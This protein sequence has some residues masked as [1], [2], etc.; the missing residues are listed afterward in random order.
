MRDICNIYAPNEDQP[1]FYVDVIEVT[2]NMSDNQIIV[3]DYN[4]VMDVSI[5]RQ[6]S[7]RNN[8]KSR[9][10]LGQIMDELLFTEVWRD[11]N[12][13]VRMFSWMR[14]KPKLSASRLDFALVSQ[15][16]SNYV[17][18][19]MYLPGI[20][21]DHLGFYLAVDLIAMD[22]GP[23]F[24][25]FNNTMLKDTE[26]IEN[27][28]TEIEKCCQVSEKM[29][30]VER[31]QYMKKQMIKLSQ[32][33]S[34]DKASE[35]SLIISQLSEKILYLHERIS[36][37][38][39]SE[40]EQEKQ[41]EILSKSKMDIEEMLEKKTQS[42][43]FKCETR[44]HEL[45]EVNSK[46]FFNLEKRRYNARVCA[47][48]IDNGVEYTDPTEILRKQERFYSDLYTSDDAVQFNMVN[49][50]GIKVPE[51]LKESQ[52]QTMSREEVAVALRQ[53]KNGKT[54]GISGLTTE[55]YKMFYCKFREIMYQAF[56]GLFE[57]EILP[58]D[59]RKGVINLIP[60]AGKDMRIL[61]NLRPI[62]LLDTD[63]KLIEKVLANRIEPAL[64][65]II[66]NDQQ[67]F[68]K[69]RRLCGNVRKILDLMKF[70]EKHNLE[71]MILS[72]DFM[73]CFDRIEFCAILGALKYFGFGEYLIN[74]VKVLY[75]D[76]TAVIQNN[77]FFSKPIAV[78]RG[79]HQ[80]GPMSSLLFLV[81]AEILAIELR[82]DEQIEGFSI[83]DIK[84]LLGQYADDMDIYLLYKQ[85]SLA[86][87]MQHLERFKMQSGFCVS[88]EKT[89]IYRIGSLKGSKAELYTHP[90]IRWTSD[91]ISVLGIKITSDDEEAIRLNYD[92]IMDKMKGIF[93]SWSNRSLSL[94]GKILVV[95]TLVASL[96]VHKMM[97]LPTINRKRC[98]GIH[99]EI[100]KFLWNGRRP[101]IQLKM[102]QASKECGG[103]NLVN[104]QWKD[105]SLKISW[106]RILEENESLANIAY[107]SFSPSLKRLTWQCNLR[108]SDVDTVLKNC[109][110]TFWRDVLKSWTI[111]RD[112]QESKIEDRLLMWW[113]SEI[114]IK[115][116]PVFWKKYFDKGLIWIWQLYENT[117]LMTPEDAKQ[118]FGLSNMDYNSLVSAIPGELKRHCEKTRVYD[119]QMS[120]ITSRAA[121][122]VLSA[123]DH[124]MLDKCL[125]W[126]SDLGLPLD[127]TKFVGSCKTIYSVT[128]VGKFRSFQYRLIHRA[129]ITNIH[130]KRWKMK[131]SDECSFCGEQ[132]E[133]YLHL[134]VF[135]DKVRD[136]WIKLERFLCGFRE[137]EI[138]FNSQNVIFNSLVEDDAEH[139]KNFICLVTKQ[140]I[141][142]QRCLHKTLNFKELKAYV[143]NIK[144]MEKYIAIK[145]NRISKHVKKWHGVTTSTLRGQQESLI[146]E[147]IN[148]YIVHT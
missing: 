112:Q 16:L 145:N 108:E 120:Y 144:S 19:V 77:G 141:Y 2:K 14:T 72:L 75:T 54:P 21:S 58:P 49:E 62:T 17:S 52:N 74:W 85:E 27:M 67:G 133:T 122:L 65:T 101:K 8:V 71:G 125:Q 45:G 7:T 18:N 32:R 140:F 84:N 86:R 46:F 31:W 147:Y 73:K 139:V 4:L 68:M 38:K 55:F 6:G 41:I 132:R 111:Y 48:L 105:I 1:M 56:M 88:Y 103:A 60:K 29:E 28:N 107:E 131:E 34:R 66:H 35:K 39:L 5:D 11:R 63:L 76:F 26:F 137:T 43:I 126:E 93:K 134:F 130:L 37:G 115:D 44:W 57:S 12:P 61:T 100:E 128:N 91:P 79:V 13:E 102:L 138:N 40:K 89:N 129:I 124:N 118:Q 123:D 78:N 33:Q 22:R 109:N 116:S 143:L 69:N 97:V 106:I 30:K 99:R 113:N 53:L 23:G 114:R 96:F 42:T 47:R 146:D 70:A 15:G 25:K 87:V 136:L 81:C 117:S 119:E 127:Y 51:E 94:M 80:G 24:W 50:T 92:P 104:L 110:N 82:G 20:K 135:C 121:Y 148:E 36:S 3:G 142:R 10:A 64:E 98:E 90:Q 59:M 83:N 9:E 95:N